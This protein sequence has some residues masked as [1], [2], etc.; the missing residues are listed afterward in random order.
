MSGA[1]GVSGQTAIEL[2]ALLAGPIVRR[3]EAKRVCLWIATSQAVHVT[4]EIYRLRGSELDRVGSGEAESVRLAERLF[5]HLVQAGPEEE[6][7][8]ADELLA[9]DIEL[10]EAPEPGSSR[11][12][13]D[14][15]LLEGPQRITYGRMPLPTFFIRK[16][17]AALNVMHGSCRL[18]HG[19]GEDA[20]LCADDFLGKTALDP[21]E[22]PSALVLTGDQIYADEVAGPLIHHVTELAREIVGP[23][24][25]HS[26]PGT[27]PL[28][29]IPVYGRAQVVKDAAKFTSDKA[30]NHLMSFGEFVA[31]YLI[32]WNCAVW[33]AQ[34][35]SPGDAV[36]EEGSRASIARLRSKYRNEVTH[37]ERARIA[38]PAV[39]RV[40]ANVPTY[41]IFDDHDTT[42]DWNLT[43][44]WRDE[45]RASHT[46]RRIVSNALASFWAFQGWG[47]DPDSYDEA[48]KQDI[49][50]YV[51]REAQLDD[52]FEARLWSFDRWSFRVPTEPP[53]IVLDTRMQRSYDSAEGAARLVGA[54]ALER[55]AALA[56]EGGHQP[57]RRL[58][59]VSAVPVFGLEVQERRQKYLVDKVGPYEIDFEAWH[60]NL[61]GHLDLMHLLIEDLGVSFGVILS[62]DIHYGLNARA[63]FTIGDQVMSAA[64][65]V[66]SAQ[67]HSGALSKK[68]LTALGR[69][70]SKEHDRVGWDEPPETACSSLVRQKLMFRVPNIDEWNDDSPVFLNPKRVGPL[71]IA[72]PPR[73]REERNYVRVE[74]PNSSMLVGENNIGLLSLTEGEVVHRLLSRQKGRTNVHTAKIEISARKWSTREAR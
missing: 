2:D 31:M 16:D 1:P 70:V 56:R 10:R 19:R 55:V 32:A 34:F 38:L 48:F 40:L 17:S 4:A 23:H 43:R 27:P 9:Y 7:F 22:R 66:S 25:E 26:V 57:G 33:P 61:R 54:A 50:A 36:Q 52:P 14:L 63:S 39:R 67:K 20:M 58:V 72:E 60:S 5:V 37:L 13:A 18:L 71:K 46:G 28:S 15:G 45:V 44:K 6:E 11:K 65:L 64:Q 29:E 51:A 62:G 42:D 59:I 74:G 8:P 35:R 12:L 21:R 30:E 69:V 41:M 47:N 73:Y 53:V 49:A 68:M 24:D 3:V